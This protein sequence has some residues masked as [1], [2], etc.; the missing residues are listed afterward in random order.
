[1]EMNTPYATPSMTTEQIAEKV[2]MAK[3]WLGENWVMHPKY[4]ATKNPQHGK[5]HANVLE[6]FTRVRARQARQTPGLRAAR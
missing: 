1:M 5:R 6:V 3:D 4:D 2:Q